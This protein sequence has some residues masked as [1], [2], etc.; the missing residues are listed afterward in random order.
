MKNIMVVEDNED[1][2]REIAILIGN[3]GYGVM[4]VD[5]FE[6]IV[7]DVKLL[8]PHLILL[9]INLPQKDGFKLCMEIRSFSKVP[10]IFVTSRNSDMDEL[11][12]ITLGGDD[13]IT[14][15]YN[16]AIL[17]ARIEAV[18]KRAYNDEENGVIINYREVTLNIASSKI[19]NQDKESELT[20][21]ELKILHYLFLH[22]GTITPRMDIVEYLWDNSM[23]IDD[24]ALSVNITR[25]REKLSTIGVD[26]FIKTKRGQG[27]MI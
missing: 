11:K 3:S 4:S 15:P 20:K 26:D 13:F 16:S 17:L 2:R 14:K 27:Y 23:F 8:K 7:E 1:I 5:D 19:I 21:T 10:I 6:N 25:I 18:L 22:R 9:D 12:S 24:N